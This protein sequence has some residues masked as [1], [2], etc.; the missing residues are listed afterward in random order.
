MRITQIVIE[1]LPTG[2]YDW[3]AFDGVRPLFSGAAE[4][5]GLCLNDLHNAL[6][7][8]DLLELSA[9]TRALL[10]EADVAAREDAA[11]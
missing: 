5:L 8:R 9:E 7:N 6:R 1:R 10:D 2:K 11:P 4:T 3:W